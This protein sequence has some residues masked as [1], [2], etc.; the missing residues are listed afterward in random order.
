[1]ET[2]EFIDNLVPYMAFA[3]IA[4]VIAFRVGRKRAFTVVRN[5]SR[6]FGAD[7]YYHYIQIDCTTLKR[8]I[9][10]HEESFGEVTGYQ[11]IPDGKQPLLFTSQQ[12]KRA[13]KRA[14]D[15]PEDFSHL[16]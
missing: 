8:Q 2:Q 3:F 1:M 9:R 15:N 5:R 16:T 12:I 11:S 13:L 7:P 6:N 14:E 4:S 10:E